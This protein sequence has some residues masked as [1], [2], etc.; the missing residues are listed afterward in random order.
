M[1]WQ[2]ILMENNEFLWH[3]LLIVRVCPF[4]SGCFCFFSIFQNSIRDLFLFCIACV[5]LCASVKLVVRGNLIMCPIYFS[6]L[7]WGTN[8]TLLT[9]YEYKYPNGATHSGSVWH[10]STPTP[11]V[12]HR[13]HLDALYVRIH[14]YVSARA[15]A[16]VFCLGLHMKRS[17]TVFSVG[18]LYWAH[19]TL[20]S[21]G[22][23]C[24][25]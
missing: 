16:S 11:V 9:R 1:K 8:P 15:A 23:S 6:L 20:C 12:L 10:T 13:R 19:W 14:H 18:R 5:L 24:K 4:C 21:C 2:K 7:K 3:E 22:V 17:G 25:H